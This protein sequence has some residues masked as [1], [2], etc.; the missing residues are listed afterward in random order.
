MKRLIAASFLVF[1]G[2]A[3]NAVLADDQ[4]DHFQAL[5]SPD[6][7]TAM[8]NLA[9]YNEKLRAILDQDTLSG[10]DMAKVHKLTYTLENALG[11][12]ATEVDD[13]AAVLEEVHLASERGDKG[14]VRSEGRSYLSTTGKLV[15]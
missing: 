12:I 2:M 9:E 14:T 15:D 5:E 13:V 7:E 1:A 8:E 3:S 6:L 4:V 11:R 10:N